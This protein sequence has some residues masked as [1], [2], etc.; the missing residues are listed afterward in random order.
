MVKPRS[1]NSS[2][3]VDKIDS[4]VKPSSQKM[5]S[6]G[7]DS[8]SLRPKGMG[9][10]KQSNSRQ[11][12]DKKYYTVKPP[13]QKASSPV[14]TTRN[15]SHSHSQSSSGDMSDSSQTGSSH[16]RDISS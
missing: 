8:S 12:S 10:P 1:S 9:K 7:Q 3:H 15:S 16:K 4:S 6:Y 11:D 13:Q 2:Q 14:A 5:R